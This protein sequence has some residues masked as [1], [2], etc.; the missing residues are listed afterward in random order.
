MLVRRVSYS[1][2]SEIARSISLLYGIRM[3]CSVFLLSFLSLCSIVLIIP[4]P[5]SSENAKTLPNPELRTSLKALTSLLPR[6]F[7]MCQDSTA[8]KRRAKKKRPILRQS[9]ARMLLVINVNFPMVHESKVREQCK[10]DCLRSGLQTQAVVRHRHRRL[11]R[12][13]LNREVLRNRG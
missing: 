1:K 8:G 11:C 2:G 13:Y 6:N 4:I 10:A 5:F 12:K 3:L 9:S 7:H